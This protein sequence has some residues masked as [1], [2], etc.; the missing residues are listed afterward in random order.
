MPNQ[1]INEWMDIEKY[2]LSWSFKKIYSDLFGLNSKPM[3][4]FSHFLNLG[5]T[6]SFAIKCG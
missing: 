2:N 3:W 1:P 4:S 6:F 5:S